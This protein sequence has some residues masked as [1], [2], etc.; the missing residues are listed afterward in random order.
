MHFLYKTYISYTNRFLHVLPK[1]SRNKYLLAKHYYYFIFITFFSRVNNIFFSNPS[2][3][4][5]P[6]LMRGLDIPKNITVS[7]TKLTLGLR[8]G[9]IS[10]HLTADKLFPVNSRTITWSS[11]DEPPVWS[12][13]HAFI[14]PRLILVTHMDDLGW[15]ITSNQ[16]WQMFVQNLN[17][18]V[19]KPN[20]VPGQ[21]LYCTT[22]SISVD[23]MFQENFHTNTQVWNRLSHRNDCLKSD[24]SYL[25]VLQQQPVLSQEHQSSGGKVFHHVRGLGRQLTDLNR[26]QLRSQRLQLHDG[27]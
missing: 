10:S 17:R 3:K 22:G 6:P 12:E 21:I 18:I 15:Y 23:L 25:W 13:K 20:V 9:F 4:S 7:V 11:D 16:H 24:L 8:V 19:S 2:L 1:K 27:S 5:G 26:R 14:K